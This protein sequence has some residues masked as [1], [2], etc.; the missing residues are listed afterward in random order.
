M[1]ILNALTY[2]RFLFAEDDLGGEST[3]E[4]DDSITSEVEATD[5]VITSTEADDAE[6]ETEDDSTTE[7]GA[8]TSEATEPAEDSEKEDSEEELPE[9]EF[10]EPE[11]FQGK[12]REEVI[13]SYQNLEKLFQKKIHT[14][15]FE[16]P[17]Q[18]QTDEQSTTQTEKPDEVNEY[19]L[20]NAEVEHLETV[21]YN[22][23]SWAA[24]LEAQK[25]LQGKQEQAQ[26]VQMEKEAE[27]YNKSQA[28][29]YARRSM[30]EAAKEAGN[31]DDL[32]KFAKANTVITQEDL[33][34]Y[35]QIQEQLLQVLDIVE[36][37][38]QKIPLQV[39]G[40]VIPGKFIY[41]PDA[42]E[43]ASKLASFDSTIEKTRQQTAEQVVDSIKN[44][45]PGARIGRPSTKEKAE[46]NVKFTGQEDA[47]EATQKALNMTE[48]ERIR[49]LDG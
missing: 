6:L 32:T 1:D 9:V 41:Q 23:G 25:I 37:T 14:E 18:A 2:P 16:Q 13:S 19:G 33:D 46:L 34:K 43:K 12:S 49:F 10:E 7:E 48:A 5:E 42:F 44:G 38:I 3:T 35:P 36:N 21:A 22:K 15:Q 39:N 45:K 26:V 27:H 30:Y 8:S 17:E 31:R 11:K 20:T 24:G 47:D 4:T 28:R 29:S 40:R